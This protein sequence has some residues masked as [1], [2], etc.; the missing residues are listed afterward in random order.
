MKLQNNP[1]FFFVISILISSSI[2]SGQTVRIEETDFEESSN[3]FKVIYNISIDDQPFTSFLYRPDLLEKP[4][5]FPVYAP[6]GPVITRGYPL[7]PRAGE[8]VDHPHHVGLW[9]NY[10]SINGIDFWNNS[11]AIPENEKLKYGKVTL[12]EWNVTKTGGKEGVLD[13]TTYWKDQQGVPHLQEDTRYTFSGSDGVWMIDRITKL[14]TGPNMDTVAIGDNKE[15]LLAIRMDRAFEEPITT[16]EVFT[17]A[18]GKPSDV[19]ALNNEGVNGVYRNSSK[20]KGGAVWGKRANWVALTATKEG[21][22]ITIAMIDHPDNFGHPAHWHAR[23]YGLFSVN[24]LGS[25]IYVPTDADQ[26]FV[27]RAGESILLRHRVLIGDAEKISDSF[28]DKQVSALKKK[29]SK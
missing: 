24:N 9:L 20:L 17:D 6:Q 14:T 16:P 1:A 26:S 18:Q 12:E 23:G 21:K 4:V 3:T 29:Y 8:R 13:F 22:K 7:Q 11:F 27:L 15:G 5:L 28:L 10:G 25:K 2:A 19:P